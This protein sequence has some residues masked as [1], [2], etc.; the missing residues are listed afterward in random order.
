MAVSVSPYNPTQQSGSRAKNPPD[1]VI[2]SREPTSLD[3]G[4]FIGTLWLYPGNSLWSLSTIVISPTQRYATWL[5]LSGTAQETFVTNSGSAVSVDNSINILGTNGITTSGTGQTITIHG[6]GVEFAWL[7]VTSSTQAMLRNTGYVVS[8]GSSLVTF[9]LPATAA[10]GDTYVVQ[11]QSSG[12]WKVDVN[13]GQILN[14]GAQPTTITTGS[15]AST[16]QW[17]SITIVCTTANTTF[18]ANAWVGNL[19]IL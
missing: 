7:D 18:A 17:N 5:S 10:I 16:N 12:G 15:A 2:I 13:T 4:Y 11:G 8:N 14:V 6:P 3:Y 9:T 19:T 1:L